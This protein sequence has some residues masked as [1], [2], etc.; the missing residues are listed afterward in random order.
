[1]QHR[2]TSPGNGFS[3]RRKA[4]MLARSGIRRKLKKLQKKIEA[5]I[6]FYSAGDS[7]NTTVDR[8]V[9][10]RTYNYYIRLSGGEVRG[11]GRQWHLLKTFSSAVSTPRNEYQ[12]GTVR[13]G[14]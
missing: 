3:R 9:F 12:V 1:M 11:G 6:R 8:T 2:E 7:F 4:E 14:K 10:E 5:N 13:E